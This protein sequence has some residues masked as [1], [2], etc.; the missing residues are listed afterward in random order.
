MNQLPGL[1][2]EQFD[3][4]PSFYRNWV[5]NRKFLTGKFTSYLREFQCTW[6]GG[7]SLLSP[8]LLMQP[9]INM[10]AHTFGAFACHTPSSVPSLRPASPDSIT[11]LNNSNGLRNFFR[12]FKIIIVAYNETGKQY[13]RI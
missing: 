11:T 2:F 3:G 8:T 7:L 4:L 13:R 10:Q 1:Q 6:S 9:C 5:V 12:F